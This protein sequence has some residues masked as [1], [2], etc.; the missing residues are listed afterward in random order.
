MNNEGNIKIIEISLETKMNNNAPT[1]KKHIAFKIC[2]KDSFKIVF[3]DA[4][5]LKRIKPTGISLSSMYWAFG[6]SE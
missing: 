2:N 6:Q 1:T 3:P 5:L 4:N